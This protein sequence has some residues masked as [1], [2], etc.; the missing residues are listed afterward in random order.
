[1]SKKDPVEC[2]F[3]TNLKI[4]DE[5]GT[6]NSR[7]IMMKPFFSQFLGFII[8]IT[9]CVEKSAVSGVYKYGGLVLQVGGC[10]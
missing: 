10:A 1:L 5:A 6:Q 4:V 2:T 9:V 3:I 7:I 8:R